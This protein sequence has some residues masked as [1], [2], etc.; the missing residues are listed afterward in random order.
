[1]TGI[2]AT[3]P[4][5]DIQWCRQNGWPHSINPILKPLDGIDNRDA[6]LSPSEEGRNEGDFVEAAWPHLISPD[7]QP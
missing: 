6:L 2:C 5:G 1:M 7:S 3:T 4:I